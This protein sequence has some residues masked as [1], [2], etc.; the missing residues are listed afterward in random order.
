MRNAIR[1][2]APR[3]ASC[4]PCPATSDQDVHDPVGRLDDVVEVATEQSAFAAGAVAGDDVDARVVQ[5]QRGGQQSA[6]QQRVLPGPQLGRVQVGGDQLG[7][8]ALDRVQQRATQHFRLDAALDQVVLG[9]GGDCRRPEILVVEPGQHD[10]RHGG[11]QLGHAVQRVDPAGV[12]QVQ[13]QQHAIGAGGFQLAFGVRHRLGP[14]HPDVGGRVGDQVFH[15]HRVGAVVLDQEQR[16]GLP[17]RRRRDRST[18]RNQFP[19]ICGRV[20][21]VTFCTCRPPGRDKT[22]ARWRWSDGIAGACLPTVGL[23]VTR[24]GDPMRC[25]RGFPNGPAERISA[26]AP[27]TSPRAESDWCPRRSG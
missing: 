6:F 4:G 7:A 22:L 2:A 15:E 16:Q 23:D 19:A 27:A 9:A 26:A 25:G 20:W 5:Q 11:V 14:H 17:T 3:A 18:R 8:L 10:D 13:I 21:E 24:R 12:G 1:S